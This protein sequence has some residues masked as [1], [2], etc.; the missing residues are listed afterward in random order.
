[1]TGLGWSDLLKAIFASGH[2][3]HKCFEYFS[4]IMIIAFQLGL[5]YE[6]SKKALQYFR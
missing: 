6:H 3:W 4:L 2:R 5:G 1:M